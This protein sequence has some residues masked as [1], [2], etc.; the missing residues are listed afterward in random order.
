MVHVRITD[1]IRRRVPTSVV[2]GTACAAAL[3]AW[4]GA[5]AIDTTNPASAGEDRGR[6]ARNVVLFIG[7]GMGA[8]HRTFFREALK[9]HTGE[10]AM[11]SL[12]V[13][14][15]QHTDPED[16]KEP[17]TDSAAAGTAIAAGVKTVNGAVGV[18]KDG[19]PVRTVLEAARARGRATGL[20]TTSQVTDAT[21]ASFAAHTSDRDRQSEI[22]RQ[23]IEETKPDVILGGG[24]DWWLPAGDAGAHPDHPA[25]DPSE[26]S[27]ST[28][29]D[30]V[31]RARK[32]GYDYV[33]NAAEL[34]ASRSRKLLGLFANEE[35]FQA[36]PE[37]RGD[38]YDPGVSLPDMTA[39]AL[40]T[41]NRSRKGFFLMVEEEAI[42]EMSHKNNARR[43]LAA[44]KAL[45]ASVAVARRYAAAHPDTLVLV[46]AD[47]ECGG[48]TV[49]DAA[50]SADESGD[51]SREDGPFPIPGTRRAVAVDWTTTGHTG[52]DVPLTA[53]GPGAELF[54]GV[55]QDTAIHDRILKA[56]RLR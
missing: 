37:G 22:A 18:D 4:A 43:T 36:R 42:D 10:L 50:D 54:T 34:R 29:G 16:P 56:A 38:E 2:V 46:T 1:R 23:Y 33:S 45:D 26:A 9:G 49:E 35:M 30:L 41:L 44:G 21:P 51:K 48:L 14:G 31:A 24:E 52:V 7:D 11:D 17:I 47:H 12:P 13:A 32:L 15:V 53:G 28:G 25:D 19:S 6:P 3:A 40:A 27:K 8:A 55:Y 5:S 20:V 39:K